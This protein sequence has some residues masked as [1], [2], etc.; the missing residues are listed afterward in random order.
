MSGEKKQ[1][2]GQCA[3]ACTHLTLT[4]HAF[5]GSWKRAE[6]KGTGRKLPPSA[7]GCHSSDASKCKLSVWLIFRCMVY[8]LQV[9]RE[10]YMNI[11]EGKHFRDH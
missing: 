2:Q 1:G 6:I 3:G 5:P 11:T 7:R 4:L 10:H 9:Q 8:P